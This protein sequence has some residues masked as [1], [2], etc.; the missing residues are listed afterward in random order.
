MLEGGEGHCLRI[1]SHSDVAL[2]QDTWQRRVVNSVCN[3]AFAAL[4]LA[5][6]ITLSSIFLLL[7]LIHEDV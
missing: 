1:I 3:Y 4:L 6:T 5:K 2:L 7:L